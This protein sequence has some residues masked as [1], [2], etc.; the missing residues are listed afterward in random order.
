MTNRYLDGAKLSR[1][2]VQEAGRLGSTSASQFRV[3][4]GHGAAGSIEKSPALQ[5]CRLPA[6]SDYGLSC[7]SVYA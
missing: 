3:T 2:M 7:S 4:M 1:G 6:Q 5:G